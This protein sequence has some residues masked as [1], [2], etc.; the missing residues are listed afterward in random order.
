M[1]SF[2]TLIDRNNTSSS[3]WDAR[4]AIFGTED[5]LPMWVADMDF[6][7]PDAVI[8]ALHKKVEHGIFG[9]TYMTDSYKQAVA[10]WMQRRFGWTIQPD[11]IVH[12]PGVVPALHQIV[13]AFTEPGDQVIIQPPVY[14][15]F[16]R[17]VANQGRELVLNPLR[18]DGD[19]YSIDFDHL[20]SLMN[21]KVKL[22]ILCSPHNPVG[23]VWSREEL[24]QLETI[25]EKHNILIVSDEIHADIVFQPNRHIPYASLSESASSRSIICTAPSK[26]FNLAGLNTSNVIIP[27]PNLR[28]KLAT[29][30][31]K[32]EMT[33]MGILGTAAAEAAYNHGEEWL[34]QCLAYIRSNLEYVH[35]HT[36]GYKDSNGSP[37]IKSSLPEATYLLWLDFGA[38]GMD[39]KE[40]NAF[41][42]E[43]ARL[44]L[45]DG[46]AFGKEGASFMRM[47]LACPRSTAEEAMA[48]LDLAMQ[49]LGK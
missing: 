11:S 24:E 33:G 29:T 27:N 10:D 30:M 37:L 16:Y 39:S 26:T 15:P 4:S 14:P 41:I 1:T 7:A 44:G 45:N 38:L 42:V 3:K 23:R 21:D 46:S 48:R 20:E 36:S 2:N 31:R 28:S 47:N 5:V 43:K 13:Q 8:Q 32:N 22:L 17:V 12:S 25:A 9:Y 40:L 18:R 49:Q 19:S 35:R 6:R 34:D